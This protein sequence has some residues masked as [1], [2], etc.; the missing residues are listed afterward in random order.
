M[1]CSEAFL[2]VTP[3]RLARWFVKEGNTY[4]VV[5]ELREMCIFSQHSVIKDAPFSRLDMISCR[6]LLIYLNAD[7][8]DRVASASGLPLPSGFKLPF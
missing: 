7:L 3:E 6:N 5:K 4:C 1:L 8:Q 2:T